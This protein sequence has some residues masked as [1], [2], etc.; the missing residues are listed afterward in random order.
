MKTPEISGSYKNKKRLKFNTQDVLY[1]VT[2]DYNICPNICFT[3]QLKR[4]SI[5]VLIEQ[6]HPYLKTTVNHHFEA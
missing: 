2:D 1:K 4:N 6:Q 3:D 5:F